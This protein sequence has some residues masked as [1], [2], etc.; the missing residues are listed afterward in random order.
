MP[1]LTPDLSLEIE[2]ESGMLTA[3]QNVAPLPVYTLWVRDNMTGDCV[4]ILDDPLQVGAVL[5]FNGISQLI[6]QMDPYSIHLSSVL[7]DVDGNILH[8]LVFTRDNQDGAG[9]V[10]LFTGPISH[11]AVDFD[12]G[13]NPPWSLLVTA[14]SDETL[15]SGDLALPDTDENFATNAYDTRT[16]QV[17]TN[18]QQYVYYNI[19]PGAHAERIISNLI[20][21]TDPA[22]GG[23]VTEAVRFNTLLEVE[24]N[25]AL[26]AASELGFQI[27]Q[28]LTSKQ[29]HWTVFQPRN[30]TSQAVFSLE[31]GNL[32]KIHYQIDQPQANVA[33]EG[34]AGSGTARL[35]TIRTNSASLSRWGRRIE[36][37]YNHSNLSV[38]ADLQNQ[39]DADLAADADVFALGLEVAESDGCV[40]LRDWRLGDLVTAVVDIPGLSQPI[41]IQDVVRQVVITL[42]KGQRDVIQPVIG[43]PGAAHPLTINRALHKLIYRQQKAVST[44]TVNQ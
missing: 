38:L 19:G 13:Q 44:L 1:D 8:G 32:T 7:P 22:I 34:G 41:V 37:F 6:V 2:L 4:D 39:G 24:Q 15:L 14:D 17:S 16:G 27:R 18:M 35:F 31:L 20:L 10:E 29:L 40:F 26:R 9:P 30:Q 12:A 28:P 11:L 36:K 33:Y 25:L 5:N 3:S 43:A 23:S 21:D 42:Q